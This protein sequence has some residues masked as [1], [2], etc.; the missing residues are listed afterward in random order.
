MYCPDFCLPEDSK[1]H[2][3]TIKSLMWK[4][5]ENCQTGHQGNRVSE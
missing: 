4:D 2:K 1:A 3:S 5:R